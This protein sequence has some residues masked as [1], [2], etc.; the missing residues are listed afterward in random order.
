VAIELDGRSSLKQNVSKRGPA[1]RIPF[2]AGAFVFLLFLLASGLR[3]LCDGLYDFPANPKSLA[4]PPNS[5]IVCLAGGKHRIDAAF[6]LFAEDVGEQF[7][8]IGAGPKSTVM[9]LARAH[10]PSAAM[11]I[12]P[13]RWERISV[14][15][16]SRNTIE[17]AFAV[18]R[19][20]QQNPQVKNLILVTSAYHMRRAQF[21]IEHQIPMDVNVIPYSPPMEAIERGT[22]WHSLLGIEVTVSEYF[23]FLMATLL[24]PRLG[25][26]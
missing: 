26:F 20:L 22:W 7:V 17:N 13:S 15:T 4:L 6:T 25:Y 9:S 23:K 12:P 1:L 2:W 19:Y 21:M 18:K 3:F 24:I 5:A 11:K 10:A 14:E 8:V 16:E